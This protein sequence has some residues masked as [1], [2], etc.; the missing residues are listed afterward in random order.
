MYKSK[1]RQIISSL[2]EK[3]CSVG[4][5]YEH[6]KENLDYKSFLG[7]QLE[8]IKR[9]IETEKR[10]LKLRKER[11]KDSFGI[12]EAIERRKLLKLLG[13]TIAWILLEF[14]RPYIRNFAR[15]HDSGFISGKKG[16]GLE[17]LALKTAFEFENSA[18]ILHDITNC[19]HIGD[20]SVIGPKGILTLELK[21]K[22]KKKMDR[23]EIRQKRRMEIVREFYDKRISTKLIKGKTSVRHLSK[24]RDKHNW[25]ELFA[26]IDEAIRVGYGIRKVEKCL[27]Y[28]AI[29][30]DISIDKVIRRIARTKPFQD[31]RIVFGCHDNH[32]DIGLPSIMPFTCFEIPVLYKEK[33]LFREVNFCVMLD[34]NS[35]CRIMEENG[36]NC[37]ISQDSKTGILEVSDKAAESEHGEIGFG[38]IDRLLYECLSID[39]VLNYLKEMSLMFKNKEE[40]SDKI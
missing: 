37:R 34:L 29:R 39:T 8:L 31:A 21:L 24:N 27:I 40:I 9:I 15:G 11:P 19:L 25:N 35:L 38:I 7:V 18:A 28:C 4:D 6:H 17:L 5:T 3:I 23:R 13:T 12:E 26:V 36:Y 20:L 14:D 30:N 16:L 32:I 22:K 10:I 2:I 1:T 33:L